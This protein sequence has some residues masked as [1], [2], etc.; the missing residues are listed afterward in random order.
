MNVFLAALAG[1]VLGAVLTWLVVQ[2]RYAARLATAVTERDGLRTQVQSLAAASTEDRHTAA[3]LA[4]M[5]ATLQHVYE[6]VAE[7]ERAREQQFGALGSG[8]TDV[9]RVTDQ[10]RSETATLT[11]ALKT[12]THAGQ[13]GEAELRRILEASG[14]LPRVDFEEQTSGINRDGSGVRPDAIVKLPGDKILVVDA[15]APTGKF[16]AASADGLSDTERA[17]L[18]AQHATALRGYVDSLGKK[19]YWTA[20]DNTPELVICFVP[21]EA[22][23]AAALRADPALFERAIEQKVVL[24]S[25]AS[26]FAIL[27]ATSLAWQQDSLTTNARELLKVGQELYERLST[28]GTHTATLGKSLEKSV[29]TYNALVGSLESRV[30]VSARKLH[31]LGVAGEPPAPIQPL[32]V[33]PRS[34]SAPELV[35]ALPDVDRPELDFRVSAAA[36]EADRATG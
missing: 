18:L 27:R 14:M 24:A 12:S 7:L 21:S 31:E 11:G 15:K 23:L 25:P 22:L 35:E 33:A 10:L 20:F 1:F 13:W 17:Q 30:L 32:E 8:L 36:S 4:P 6:Q 26:L 2:S 34:L 29:A 5:R 19:A 3:E 28:L 16:L 9:R